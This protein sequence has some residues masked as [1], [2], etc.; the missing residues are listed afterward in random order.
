MSDSQLDALHHP[1][2]VAVFGASDSVDKVGGRPI[3]F[4]KSFGFDG[5]VFPINPARATVQGLP[6]YPDVASLPSVPD[7]TV[8][9]VP[10]QKAVDAVRQ[11][12]A[13]G[14]KGCVVLASGFAETHEPEGRA[15]QEE[16]VA[17]A[18]ASGMRLVGPN[19]HGLAN[20]GSG[21]VLSFSTMFLQIEPMD[22]PVALISQSG[23][24]SAIAYG[25]L[26]H[27]GIGIRY[28][29]GTGN[30]ADTSASELVA[31]AAT[32]PELRLILL[33][34]EGIAD[35]NAFERAASASVAH[36]VPI[37]ALVGGSSADGARAA[38]SHTGSLA[39]EKVV[40]EAFLEK[41]GVRTV[42]SMTELADCVQLYLNDTGAEVTGDRLAIVSNSGG[43]C[44]LASDH[45]STYGLPLA[46][47]DDRTKHA[48]A[49]ALPSFASWANPIDI[50]GMLLKDS[51]LVRRVLDC[52][53]EDSGPDVFLLSLPVAG[54]GYNVDEFASA[55]RVFARRIRR[56]FVVVSPQ[57]EV[58][59][60]F[61]SKGLTVYGDDDDALRSL[62]GYLR[63]RRAIAAAR[64][65][66]PVDLR[67]PAERSPLLNE[68]DSLTILERC[69]DVVEHV[70]VDDATGAVEA[71]DALGRR[72]VVVKGCTTAVSHKSDLGLVRLGCETGHDVAAAARDI[73]AAMKDHDLKVD[74]LLVEPMLDAAFEVMVG[75]HRDP[76][77]GAVVMLGAGGKYIEAVPDF[78]TLVPPFGR[79]EVETA[80]RSLRMAPLLD[81][82]RGEPPTDVTAWVDL[83]IGVGE[84]MTDRDGQVDSLDANPVLLV[85]DHGGTR[86]VVADA[87][88]V[89]RT[90]PEE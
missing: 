28:V 19:A 56:P 72:P 16:M 73:L 29:H 58:A 50:T 22:G 4:L 35:A 30:D 83:V 82:V 44:V 54:R 63:H 59:G 12:A 27:R 7:V 14:V 26:R 18:K 80:I 48:L 84:L 75:A 64:D 45:A 5:D 25:L 88:V 32:D 6:A 37:V 38:Q 60:L 47:L 69:G 55:A 66:G 65:R 8:I 9:A 77:L 20:F 46:T 78:A 81:G 87:V 11:S 61:R 86:A 24:M 71:F 57:P 51:S 3:H 34:I 74:G 40:V 43:V 15:M 49:D 13:A 10:G 39:S 52:F 89:A 31:A 42:R 2:S 76:S 62:S 36:G 17:L 85:R 21:A 53:T 68:H 41:L 67:R 70:L 79:Q 1:R 90:A 33:Y 23:A